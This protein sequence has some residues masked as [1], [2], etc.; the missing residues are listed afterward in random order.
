MCL[1]SCMFYSIIFFQTM[2]ALP[3]IVFHWWIQRVIFPFFSYRVS[4]ILFKVLLCNSIDKK[5]EEFHRIT[6]HLMNA[7]EIRLSKCMLIYTFID[8]INVSEFMRLAGWLIDWLICC[9]CVFP[10][11]SVMVV[12]VNMLLDAKSLISSY[13]GFF[14]V[15]ARNVELCQ[16]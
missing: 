3:L 11:K 1:N 4:S 12:I 6:S 2:I 10:S 14:F 7:T 16:S 13:L 5:R 8:R 9:V 15:W